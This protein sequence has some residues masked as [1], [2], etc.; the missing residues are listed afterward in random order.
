M[1]ILKM[2]ESFKYFVGLEK[3]KFVISIDQ[4]IIFKALER[5][6][7]GSSIVKPNGDE[8]SDSRSDQRNLK[9]LYK[10]IDKSYVLRESSSNVAKRYFYEKELIC[11]VCGNNEF[12]A[13]R[14]LMVNKTEA[15]FNVEQFSRSARNF[16]CTKGK[17]VLW[18]Y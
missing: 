10:W 1:S 14:T 3:I 13:R 17:H 11:P 12:T 5:E 8:N 6:L 18:F 15:F 16:I 9:Y 4:E 7:N 2:I